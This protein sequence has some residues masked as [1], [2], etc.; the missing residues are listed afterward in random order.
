[1]RR[2]PRW[3]PRGLVTS[4]K[5]STL[6]RGLAVPNVVLG[7]VDATSCWWLRATCGPVGGMFSSGLHRMSTVFGLSRSML[8]VTLNWSQADRLLCNP[9]PGLACDREDG[10]TKQVRETLL[11]T[12]A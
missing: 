2:S 3:S 6:C 7:A 8:A 12:S 11:R 4:R 1:M 9:V 5:C 10:Y